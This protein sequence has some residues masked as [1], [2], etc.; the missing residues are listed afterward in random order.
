ML[1]PKYQQDSEPRIA[2]LEVAATLQYLLSDLDAGNLSD[3]GLQ[4]HARCLGALPSIRAVHPSVELNFLQG[5]L[6]AA[7]DRCRHRFVRATP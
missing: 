2:E 5:V 3:T 4:F 6:Y 7:T 1:D